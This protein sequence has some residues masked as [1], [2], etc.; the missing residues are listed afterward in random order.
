MQF[1]LFKSSQLKIN[2]KSSAKMNTPHFSLSQDEETLTIDIYS[3]NCDLAELDIILVE[4]QFLFSCKPYFLRITLPGIVVEDQRYKGVFNAETQEFSFTYGKKHP[5]EVFENLNVIPALLGPNMV[6]CPQGGVPI[7]FVPVPEEQAAALTLSDD[8]HIDLVK[9]QLEYDQ[10]DYRFG[11]GQMNKHKYAL[12][13]SFSE[14][15]GI[16]EVDPRE[17]SVGERHK[18][19]LQLEQGK[20]NV[21][22]Y[23]ADLCDIEPIKALIEQL[24]PYEDDEVDLRFQFTDK[25]RNFLAELETPQQGLAHEQ[26]I[27]GFHGLV[28]LLFAYCYDKRINH[29]EECSESSWNINKLAA[30]LCWLDVFRTP[31]DSITSGFRRTLIYPLH[32]HFDL[33]YRVFQDLKCLLSLPERHLTR[34]LIDMY[35]IFQGSDKSILNKL[36]I[37]DYLIFVMKWDPEHW[38]IVVQNYLHFEIQKDDV[39]LN[40]KQI[41][42]SCLLCPKMA[43]LSLENGADSDDCSSLSEYSSDESSTSDESV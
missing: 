8:S 27:Y 24:S 21:D 36:F 20:F 9:E 30:S 39:G 5:G 16:F 7:E 13:H 18:M 14:Y 34:A 37:N 29:F 15:E 26:I 31:K 22:H 17:S 10:G 19:R 42:E 4:D 25:E 11:F 35:Y 23:L 33:S 43:G 6:H 12:G 41:E 32:R 40:L 28:E 2:L 38:R 3:P 1:C